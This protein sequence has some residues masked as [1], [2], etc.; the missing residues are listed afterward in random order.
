MPST[1]LN[2]PTTTRRRTGPASLATTLETAIEN[3][4]EQPMPQEAI[5]IPFFER[6]YHAAP[7]LEKI[8]TNLVAECPELRHLRQFTVKILWRREGGKSQGIPKMADAKPAAGLAKF[9]TEADFVIWVAADHAAEAKLT[10]LQFEAMIFH[11][12]M[13]CGQ[14][15]N[16]QTNESTPATV[17]HNAEFFVE[18]IDRYGIW[19]ADI[20]SVQKRIAQKGLWEGDEM[21][22]RGRM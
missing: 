15:V 20:G 5:K 13:H 10:P 6:D 18:E 22:F 12:L 21:T 17:P 2:A 1:T 19:R 7:Q 4:D 9:Y 8:V 14:R 16:D 11:E 3:A